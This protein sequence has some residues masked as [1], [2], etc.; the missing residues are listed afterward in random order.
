MEH[1]PLTADHAFINSTVHSVYELVVAIPG[2]T[3]AFNYL[4]NA[5]QDDPFR[6]ALE[7][8]LVF[9]ALRYMLSKKYKPHDNAVKLTEKEIDELVEEWQPESLVPKLSSYDKFNLEKTPM[10]VGAQTAKTK[11]AGYTKPLMNLATTNYL[12]LVSSEHIRQ[13]AIDA[14]KNYGVG[15][16]GPPG[17]YG[18]LDIHMQLEK[19][20]ARFLGTD[21]AIIYAQNFSTISSVIPAF[22]KRGDLLVVDDRVNFAIQKGVQISRSNVRW[23]KHNDMNDLERV[24]NEIQLDTLRHKKR[25]TR[26]FI[27]TE[28]LFSNYGD[29]VPLPKLIELKKKFKYRLILDES[30]SIGVLG[31]RGAG[32][33]DHFGVDAKD[34]D[35]IVGSM[36]SALCS[37]GGFCAGSVEIVDHQRLSGSAYCFSASLP[38]ML[39]IS[40]SE[41]INIISQQ[42]NLLRELRERV[43]AFR[44]TLAH[45]SLDA[46]IDVDTS[47]GPDAAVVPF[48][49]I[50]I[51][52]SFLASRNAN[53]SREDEERLLQEVVDECASQ[54][55]LVTRAK[56]VDD[57]ERGLPRPS[58]KIHVTVGLSKKENDKAATI[59][60]SALTKVLSSKWKK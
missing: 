32:V 10:I 54:G 26:R 1:A 14:L 15:T 24:L 43:Q 6:I 4:K 47:S 58:I 48:F 36:A 19:D 34:V 28:A 57:Q 11:V 55:A 53:L 31:R 41:A 25:L 29:V 35:M 20:I 59:V 50:R 2:S 9:F 40:A 38:A 3:L 12:N 60:K 51:K 27:V 17:F 33:T 49:H 44:H 22:S 18:T 21:E 52:P 7:L 42:P 13:K 23:Y 8:F 16:C 45:K 46:L 5:Y 30:Q 37:S 39:T 56:Y